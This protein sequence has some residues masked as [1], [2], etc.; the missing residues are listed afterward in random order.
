MD[1]IAVERHTQLSHPY[2][3][4]FPYSFGHEYVKHFCLKISITDISRYLLSE[5]HIKN[6]MNPLVWL[7]FVVSTNTFH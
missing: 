5:M 6:I 4:S 2:I 3:A 7:K 1:E